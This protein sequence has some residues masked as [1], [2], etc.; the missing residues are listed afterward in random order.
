M[1]VPQSG[2]RRRCSADLS[3]GEIRS[4][5][6]DSATRLDLWRSVV[7]RRVLTGYPS[8]YHIDE[9]DGGR[10]SDQMTI[11]CSSISMAVKQIGFMMRLR[12][13]GHWSEN[14]VR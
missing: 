11:A 3:T 8:L 6:D 2:R 12:G 7:D 14:N 10:N 1:N 9:D 5:S 4:V 13:A